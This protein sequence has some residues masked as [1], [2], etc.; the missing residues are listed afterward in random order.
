MQALLTE[1]AGDLRR[2]RLQAAVVFVTALL[3]VAT[4]TMA[5]TLLSQT[6][7]TYQTAFDAQKGAHLQVTFDGRTDPRTLAGTPALIGASA[8]GGPYP[9]T[10]VQLEFGGH[11]FAIATIGRDDPGGPVEQL[12]VTAGRWPTAAGEIALTHSFAA[13]N[14]I[15]IGDR[16]KVVSV[17]QEPQLTVVAEVFDIDEGSADVS[18]QHSWMVSS[19]I[20]ALS[21]KGP[22]YY[23]MDY[24]FAGDPTSAQLQADIATLRGALPAGTV[25]S[26]VNYLVFRGI[27]DINNRLATD[28]LL[29]FSVFA[30]LATAAIV[31]NL[32]TGIVISAYREIGIMKAL[33]FTPL[34]VELVFVLQVAIPVA[35]ASLV[36]IPLGTLASQPLVAS[37][38]Q[39]LGLAY[40]SAF[41]PALDAIVLLG[42]FVVATVAAL[43]PALRAG[44][45]KPAAII[46][47]ASAPRGRSG[48]SLR[49]LAAYARLPRPAV[50]GAG[51][52]FARPL[53]AV[54]TLFAIFV[55]VT[56]ATVSVGLPRGFAAII[57]SETNIGYVDVVVRRSLALADADAMRIFTA[58]PQT[59]RV[60]GEV[61]RNVA[62]PG[63]G[64]P[65]DARIFR[66]DSSRLGFLLIAGRWFS[67]AG[68]AVAPRALMQ[69]A[70]LKI[71]DRFTVTVGSTPVSLVLVGEVYDA[72]N[73]GHTLFLDSSTIVP[74]APDAAP[75][76]Y[77]ITLTPHADVDAYVRRIAAA[78]PDLLDVQKN[79]TI[80]SPQQIDDVLL[81]VAAVIIVI[82]IAGIFNTLLLN[83]RERV[84]DTATLRAIGMSPRQVKV[85]VAASAAPLALV[86][87]AVAV[88]AGV[89]LLRVLLGLINAIGGNDTA[90]AMYQ[91][92]AAWELVAIPLAG[93]AVAVA[94]ALL[95]GRWA[96]RQPVAEVLRAE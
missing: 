35:A 24:R 53:R 60:V 41:S 94:A 23:Y 68:E 1:I 8:Y 73:L 80:L 2:R 20:A 9:W 36:A 54:L 37:S 11:K 26:S 31:A 92:F 70:H 7:D 64:D 5:L 82:G 69:D 58:D 75:S 28:V 14:H 52:A 45:L 61:D 65:V 84:R 86:G 17:P 51:D 10:D 48:R 30:L 83:A 96:A 57:D 78:Q 27:F 50:L 76:T 18:S 81:I 95:P 77:F 25:T 12:R 21:P 19:A 67:G 71:G 46:T 88:P 85:M 34:Q 13:L 6:G 66:G 87:G 16:L 63:I 89:G 43:V 79:G 74:V 49:R 33:G 90:P 62:V 3:A 93:V 72:S 55:G 44:R 29:A 40:Q 47:N 4:G 91:V 39:A 38:S 22:P 59:A 56:V 15:A 42:S 32:V